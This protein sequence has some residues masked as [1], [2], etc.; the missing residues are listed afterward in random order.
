[1]ILLG[2]YPA[3]WDLPKQDREK[4]MMLVGRSATE[5]E[6]RAH[7][8]RERG[9]QPGGGRLLPS[10]LRLSMAAGTASAGRPSGRFPCCKSPALVAGWA[11][12]LARLQSGDQG[13]RFLRLPQEIVGPAATC[14]GDRRP[15]GILHSKPHSRLEI[16]R[17]IGQRMGAGTTQVELMALAGLQLAQ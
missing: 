7:E 6:K 8:E 15:G 12:T 10:L 3:E 14:A 17:R 4:R 2:I 16:G 1:M 13:G 9:R 11:S 5:Q